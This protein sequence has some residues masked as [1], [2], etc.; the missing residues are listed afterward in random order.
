MDTKIFIIVLFFVVIVTGILFFNEQSSF[1]CEASESN[2][3]KLIGDAN[4]CRVDSDCVLSTE[5]W[6]PFGCYQVF[7]KNA[8]LTEIRE[9]VKKYGNNCPQCEYSCFALS[10]YQIACRENVC[11]LDYNAPLS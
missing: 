11:D 6:C 3:K 8:D 10:E 4:Y 9:E 5:F 7:N 2:I 1:S